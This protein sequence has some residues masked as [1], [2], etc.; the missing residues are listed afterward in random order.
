[1][2]SQSQVYF[3]GDFW[4]CIV[5]TNAGESPATHPEKWRRIDIP[6]ESVRFLAQ[7]AYAQ[8]LEGD[9]QSDKRRLEEQLADK[10]LTEGL[11]S[12]YRNR[13]HPTLLSV[14]TR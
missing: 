10:R 4:T 7:S 13:T 11:M 8:L 3:E 12:M 2:P 9:G 5:A 1:M 14:L 6:L